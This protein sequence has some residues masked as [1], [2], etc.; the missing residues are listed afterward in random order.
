[1]LL[2]QKRCNIK[3]EFDPTLRHVN[4]WPITCDNFGFMH[5]QAKM[6]E[7]TQNGGFS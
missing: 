1:M 7:M 5:A 2:I 4:E 3:G 6:L